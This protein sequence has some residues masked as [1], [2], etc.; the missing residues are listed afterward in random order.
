MEKIKTLIVVCALL[1]LP[2]VGYSVSQSMATSDVRSQILAILSKVQELQKQ[3]DELKKLEDEQAAKT[4]DKTIAVVMPSAGSKYE[5]SKIYEIKWNTTG[6]GENDLVSL[7]L[8]DD[9]FSLETSQGRATIIKTKNTGSYIWKVPETLGG[10]LL[11]GG[12]Y[13]VEAVIGDGANQKTAL[14][15]AYLPIFRSET[16][17]YL[18]VVTPNGS[19]QVSGGSKYIIKWDSIGFDN[20]KL[21]IDLYKSGVKNSNIA[22][23]VQNKGYYEWNVPQ[24]L[25]GNFKILIK[26]YSSDGTFVSQ[27]YSDNTF[28]LVTVFSN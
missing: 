17:P 2:L 15:D 19:G 9:R 7:N 16:S 13:K 4:V 6:F 18:T 14:V 22:T 28:Q 8:L 24:N 10:N 3:L 27:D 23:E 21:T 5:V 20:T 26:V 11:N 25:T 12:L 1:V